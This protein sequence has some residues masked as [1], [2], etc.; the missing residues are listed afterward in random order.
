MLGLRLLISEAALQDSDVRL[1]PASRHRSRRIHKKLIRRFGGEFKRVPCIYQMGD[2]LL[3][4]PVMA[5][6]LKQEIAQSRARHESFG[7]NPL[8]FL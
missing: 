1:F 4:H 3:A 2:T 8:G 5:H 7:S 6:R